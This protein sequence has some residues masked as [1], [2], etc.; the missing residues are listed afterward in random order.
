MDPDQVSK[1]DPQAC[2][3]V[4]QTGLMRPDAKLIYVVADFIMLKVR[5]RGLA[6]MM[7]ALR[8]TAYHKLFDEASLTLAR[9]G[10]ELELAEENSPISH[11][12]QER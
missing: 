9:D 4:V 7:E 3:A 5:Q 12:Y 8:T 1:V 6:M 10:G 2:E 11:T